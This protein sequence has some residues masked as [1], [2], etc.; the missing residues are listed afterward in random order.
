MPNQFNSSLWGDEGFSAILSMNSIPDIIRIISRDTS[1]PLYNLTEHLV[2]SVF[3]NSE[4]VIRGLSFF[5]FL[6]TVF[7]VYKIGALVWSRKTGVYAALLTFFNPFFFTYAFEGRMYSILSLGVTASM[8]F[9]LK[10]NWIGYIIATLFAL[11]SHHFAIFALFV[12]GIWMVYEFFSGNK[13]TAKNIF[14]AFIFI[15]LGYIPWIIPLYNQTRMVGGGFWLGK[16]SLEDLRNLI[17]TY[18]AKGIN[19]NLAE[20]AL[21]VSFSILLIREWKNKIKA[22]LFLLTWFLLP[23]LLTWLISQQFQSIFYSRYLLYTI[24]ALALVLAS[25]KRVPASNILISFVL[26]L[27]IFIDYFY[28]THPNKPPFRDLANYVKETQEKGDYLIIWNP[29]SHQLWESKYYGIPAPIYSP[30]QNALPYFVG[31]ALMQEGD[32]IHELPDAK[33]IGVIAPS[34]DTVKLDLYPKEDV[35]NFNSLKFVWLSK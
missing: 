15:G 21:Y 29:G 20:P 19:H 9:F 32:I 4:G 22:T 7:F 27:F 33:R 13:A 3:G 16:P 24:P 11:Y 14:K 8:Y 25:N 26:F 12:Q 6:L 10:R 34:Q 2:F 23:I 1:P 31:T 35:H 30:D 28:F 17:Y 18:I 5:Y